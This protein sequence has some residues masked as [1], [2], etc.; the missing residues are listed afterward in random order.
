MLS[1]LSSKQ[2][3]VHS[4]KGKSSSVHSRDHEPKL[5]CARR[6][7]AQEGLFLTPFVFRPEGKCLDGLSR[8]RDE[9]ERGIPYRARYRDL[10]FLRHPLFRAA[11]DG[12]EAFV[13]GSATRS[14]KPHAVE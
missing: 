10:E 1:W 13:P 11:L 7:V 9:A 4:L 3:R 12:E 14:D 6:D 2:G 8:R 5:P